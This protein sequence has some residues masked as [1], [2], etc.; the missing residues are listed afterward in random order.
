MQRFAVTA[1][2]AKN[3]AQALAKP[4][5]ALMLAQLTGSALLGLSVLLLWTAQ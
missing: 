2:P 1:L 5:D 4:A 3:A